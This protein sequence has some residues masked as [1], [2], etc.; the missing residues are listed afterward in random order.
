M[1]KTEDENSSHSKI[2]TEK[3]KDKNGDGQLKVISFIINQ[4]ESI[5]LKYH[6]IP[7]EK[8]KGQEKT[9]T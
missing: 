3:D 5:L 1:F 6:K 9:Q 8:E 4:L 2:K 7:E